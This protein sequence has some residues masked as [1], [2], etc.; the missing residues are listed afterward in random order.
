MSGPTNQRIESLDSLR[1]LAA[2]TVLLFHTVLEIS[3][4]KNWTD[5]SMTFT[6]MLA[7]L[8]YHGIEIPSIQLGRW[9][10]SRVCF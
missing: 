6:L 9:L 4:P 3:W 10:A 7:G 2:L 8:L 5:F 1:G